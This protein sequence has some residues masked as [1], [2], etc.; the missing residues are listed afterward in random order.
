[1]DKPNRKS[2]WL[3]LAAAGL[4]L[5]I[6]PYVGA[7]FLLGDSTIVFFGE[8]ARI[9]DFENEFLAKVFVPLGWAE[10]KLRGEDVYFRLPSGRGHYFERWR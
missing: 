4:L 3:P 8:D 2:N 6:G 5:T 10:A 7:Y 9:R 1:M